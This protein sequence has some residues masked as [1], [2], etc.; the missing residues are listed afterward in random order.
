MNVLLF[1]G[2]PNFAFTDSI[3]FI[4]QSFSDIK[5]M[6]AVLPSSKSSARE[7]IKPLQFKAGTRRVLEVGAGT[8]VITDEILDC[9]TDEDFLDVLEI[10]DEMCQLLR[11]KYAARKNVAV[12]QVSILDW[13][14]AYSYDIIIST[15]P[16]TNFSLQEVQDIL[17]RYEY[18]AAPGAVLSYLEYMS[19][20]WK[21]LFL[22]S[23]K[24]ADLDEKLSYI[25]TFRK[26]NRTSTVS[27][28]VNVP[29]TFAHHIVLQHRIA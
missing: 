3:L 4:K 29:P 11:K 25:D 6:G 19:V 15:L 1:T 8:G 9:L 2:L 17:H 18:L 13:S 14:P 26:K 27:V 16:L 7:L 24:A 10:D 21:K 5:K 23:E 20:G 12:H 28:Y 22:S